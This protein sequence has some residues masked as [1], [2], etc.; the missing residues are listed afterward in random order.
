[1][2]SISRNTST[3]IFQV[4]IN[5]VI[6]LGPSMQKVCVTTAQKFVDFC[7]STLRLSLVTMDADL[8]IRFSSVSDETIIRGDPIESPWPSC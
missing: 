4:S 3:Y 2:R 5:G 8:G 6:D 1:M 7:I